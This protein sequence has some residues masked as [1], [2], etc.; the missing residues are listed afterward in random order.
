MS[1]KMRFSIYTYIYLSREH[2]IEENGGLKGDII[3]LSI[4]I[5]N[6][7]KMIFSIYTYNHLSREQLIE[8]NG[9]LKGDICKL[10]AELDSEVNHYFF[11]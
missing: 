3:Y 7:W 1:W 2:L 6:S 10:K 9:G 4:Y 11:G 5:E 8:E